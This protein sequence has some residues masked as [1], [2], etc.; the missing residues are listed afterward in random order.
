MDQYHD[1]HVFVKL[2]SALH[3][4][5]SNDQTGDHCIVMTTVLCM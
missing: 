4:V 3:A 5:P 1:V 2:Y